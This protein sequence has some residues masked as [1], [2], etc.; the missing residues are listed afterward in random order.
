MGG[1]VIPLLPPKK[2]GLDGTLMI[3][4]HEGEVIQG[5]WYQSTCVR[6]LREFRIIS[7]QTELFIDSLK[8]WID[9]CRKPQ[10]QVDPI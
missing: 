1:S 3:Y 7:T 5:D 10:T 8:H 4:L 9:A 2:K 6:T